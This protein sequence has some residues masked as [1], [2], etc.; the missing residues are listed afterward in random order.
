MTKQG[1]DKLQALIEKDLL[2]RQEEA[3]A[4]QWSISL[5]GIGGEL[6]GNYNPSPALDWLAQVFKGNGMPQTEVEKHIARARP[7]MHAMIHTA[8]RDALYL[9]VTDEVSHQLLIDSGETQPLR[10]VERRI[11]K[12]SERRALAHAASHVRARMG[13]EN[14]GRQPGYSKAKLEQQLRKAAKEVVKRGDRL[15]LENVL[16]EVNKQR[17]DLDPTTVNALK[18]TIKRYGVAWKDIKD[19]VGGKQF[20]HFP[21][22]KPLAA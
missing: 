18:K 17:Q 16:I 1:K 9:F 21:R 6:N 3:N 7:I 19:A 22:E 20:R 14:R 2:Q 12:A 4:P 5:E 15:T 10:A 13:I 11:V 8:L